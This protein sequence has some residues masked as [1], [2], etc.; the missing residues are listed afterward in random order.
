MASTHHEH[1]HH[2]DQNNGMEIEM[3]MI[4]RIVGVSSRLLY[5]WWNKDDTRAC[6]SR[7][8]G[9][10][11]QT[12]FAECDWIRIYKSDGSLLHLSLS[13]DQLW[14][15]PELLRNT[16]LMNKGTYKGDVYS[17]AII[18]QEVISR[19]APF[20]MLDMPVKGLA[21]LQYTFNSL[22]FV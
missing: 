17:F 2:D 12:D 3:V 5:C 16:T 15:A 6:T 20:C 8:D 19:S 9:I 18:M 22:L 11:T 7:C 10:N 13:A 14:T 4:T 1:T 21:H